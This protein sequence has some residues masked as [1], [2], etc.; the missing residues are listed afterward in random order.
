MYAVRLLAPRGSIPGTAPGRG[1]AWG[2]RAG[3]QQCG[4]RARQCQAL[5]VHNALPCYMTGHH[6]HP[7]PA[8]S[9]APPQAH[10]PTP[11]H[12]PAAGVASRQHTSTHCQGRFI[13]ACRGTS[14]RGAESYM[15]VPAAAPRTLGWGAVGGCWLS[16]WG[17]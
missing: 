3:R 1:Q 13:V 2:R 14:G 15:S 16:G 17:K 12:S 6:H 11:T 4:A 10:T 7:A 5:H 8:A 9:A